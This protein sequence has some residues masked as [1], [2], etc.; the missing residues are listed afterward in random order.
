[1]NRTRVFEIALA[2]AVAVAFADS[3]IVVLALPELYVDLDTS[4][5][6]ISWVITAYNLVVLVATLALL[7]FVR[8]LRPVPLVL[9]GL[10]VFLAASI[11]CG[12]ANSLTVLI[13]ARAVQG[14]G[15]AM[16]L[17]GSLPAPRR[18]RGS[19][20]RGIAVWATAGT[21]GATFG[22]ALGGLL[23]EVFSW[24]AIFFVQAPLAALA[25]VAALSRTGRC[26]RPGA[27]AASPGPRRRERRA[28]FVFGALVGALF[29][30]VLMIVTVWDFG[31]LAGAGIVSLSH[32]GPRS[33]AARDPAP[34]EPR[35]R[36][37]KHSPGGRPRGARAAAGLE[38]WYAG[39]ALAICG[40][41]LGLVLPTLTHAS[42]SETSA[43]RG[44]ARFRRHASCWARARRRCSSRPCSDTSSTGAASGHARGR[45]GD[46]RSAASPHDEDPD[47][48][49]PARPFEST[50]EG[51]IPDLV[52]PFEENGAADDPRWPPSATTCWTHPR[53]PDPGLPHVVL[54]VAAVR[55]ARPRRRRSPAAPRGAFRWIARQRWCRSDEAEARGRAVLGALFVGVG[56]LIAIEFVNGAT[57]YGAVER[58]TPAPRETSSPGEGP[59]CDAAANRALG[60]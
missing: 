44:A 29:L 35:R 45:R 47:R 37:R 7:P 56:A 54:P 16:M 19:A 6:G 24:R 20:K 42:V 3:S 43:S 26:R 60:R 15:G 32:R 48:A 4:I 39:P 13:A 21:V 31:P 55:A 23:T 50:P 10:V 18:P 12:F 49:R 2:V 59:G 53:R 36:R 8:R 52:Q 27:P 40:A 14:L 11:T 38:R 5:V 57:D 1:M 51:E 30:A 28:R 46:H 9:A 58:R 41:G 33:A 34:R 22:P 25:I 17:A